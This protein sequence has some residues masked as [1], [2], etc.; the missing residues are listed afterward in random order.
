MPYSDIIYD[1]ILAILTGTIATL[2]FFF[3]LRIFK[4]NII[5]SNKIIKVSQIDSQ[6]KTI[7]SYA[8]KFINKTRSDIENVAIDLFLMED[9]FHGTAKNYK[10]KRLRVAQPEFK[11]LTGK[12][13]KD[14]HIHNNCVQMVIKEPLEDMWNGEKEWLQVQIDSKHSKSGRRTIIVKTFKDPANTIVYGKFDSGENF[15]LIK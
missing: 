11:F 8:F 6:G 10:S 1:L 14:K 12:K 13:N 4:P 7:I 15:N 9:Y 3:T 2:I 5:I